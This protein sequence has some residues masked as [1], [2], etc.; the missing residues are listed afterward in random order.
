MQKSYGLIIEPP[1]VLQRNKKGQFVKGMTPWHKGKTGVYS[2]STIEAIRA[3][4]ARQVAVT[5]EEH[6]FWKGDAVGYTSLHQ[7]IARKLG[8]PKQCSHC[9]S[10]NCKAYDWANVSGKYR[11]DFSDWVRLCRGCHIR[12]DRSNLKLV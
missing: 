12:F 3:A 1:S 6:P 4:R 9:K 2:K 5:D 10:T 8:K 7:W 11:R